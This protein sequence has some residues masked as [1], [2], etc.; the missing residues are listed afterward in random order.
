MFGYLQNLEMACIDGYTWNQKYAQYSANRGNNVRRV[1]KTAW[2][3]LEVRGKMLF[4]ISIG[5]LMRQYY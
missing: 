3:K 1:A 4:K 2:G 5:I